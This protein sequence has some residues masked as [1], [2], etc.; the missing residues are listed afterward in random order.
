MV[1]D[2]LTHVVIH[3]VSIGPEAYRPER[4]SCWGAKVYEDSML[5][6]TICMLGCK[7]LFK[8]VECQH[9][10]QAGRACNYI[11]ALLFMTLF[12]LCVYVVG[13]D[14][15]AVKKPCKCADWCNIC[16]MQ[17]RKMG[18]LRQGM[19]SSAVNKNG[20]RACAQGALYV[21]ETNS[22]HLPC[23]H[24]L[25]LLVAHL[26]CECHAVRALAAALF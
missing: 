8:K 13:S 20:A 16:C 5:A 14:Q 7:C 2:L 6:N 3:R 1:L 24:P 4:C 19:H 11:H 23:R 10:I 22:A 15:Y 9:H 25:D 12:L 26:M 18:C 21:Y 17:T